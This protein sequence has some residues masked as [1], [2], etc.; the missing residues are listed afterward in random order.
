MIFGLSACGRPPFSIPGT[1]GR[2]LLRQN[3]ANSAG[4]AAIGTLIETATFT[5]RSPQNA[6]TEFI[7]PQLFGALLKFSAPATT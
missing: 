7:L 6:Q 1:A 4:L 5:P 3:A 2:A